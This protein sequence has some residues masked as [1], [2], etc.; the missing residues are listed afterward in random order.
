MMHH[1]NQSILYTV[2]SFLL[3]MRFKQSFCGGNI[4]VIALEQTVC[5]DF[6]SRIGQALS[7]RNI[8]PNIDIARACSA[9]NGL[10]CS[11]AE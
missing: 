2:G 5:H 9:P 4:A 11:R 3:N 8:A 6:I 7:Y 1:F 10:A